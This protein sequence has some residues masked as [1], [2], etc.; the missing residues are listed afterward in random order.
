MIVEGKIE[1]GYKVEGWA[2]SHIKNVSALY[3]MESIEKALFRAKLHNRPTNA[4][5]F[6]C[7]IKIY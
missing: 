1:Q 7:D 6:Q 4:Y 2:G 3:R 5:A